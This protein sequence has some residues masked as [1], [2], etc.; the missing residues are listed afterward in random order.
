MRAPP[1]A[2]GIVVLL[3]IIAL[4]VV[5][6]ARAVNTQH[7]RHWN[8]PGISGCPGHA[9]YAASDNAQWILD[10]AYD[11]SY[12]LRSDAPGSLVYVGYHGYWDSPAYVNTLHSD[13]RPLRY[14]FFN[15]AH[16]IPLYRYFLSWEQRGEV[17][18]GVWFRTTYLDDSG[19]YGDNW[20]FLDFDRSE[21]FSAY[22]TPAGYLGFSYKTRET[23]SWWDGGRNYDYVEPSS[24]PHLADGEWHYA[25]FTFKCEGVRR[26]E[27]DRPYRIKYWTCEKSTVRMYRDG[28]LSFTGAVPNGFCLGA[29][30]GRYTGRNHRYG[31]IGDGSEASR[32]NRGRNGAYYTGDIAMVHYSPYK[33]ATDAQVSNMYY[34]TRRYY[35]S[36]AAG[37]YC[38]SFE[39]VTCPAGYYCPG[40]FQKYACGAGNYCPPGSNATNPVPAGFAPRNLD[41]AL[42]T[43]DLIEPCPA[44][45]YCP[46][47]RTMPV[48]GGSSTYCP[49][50]SSAPRSVGAGNYSVGNTPV[51]RTAEVPCNPGQYCAL[52]VPIDC[53]AG[54]YGSTVG[55]ATSACSGN[56]TAGYYCPA[57]SVRRKQEV[58]GIGPDPAATYCPGGHLCASAFLP[59]AIRF[60]RVRLRHDATMWLCAPLASAAPVGYGRPSSTGLVAPAARTAPPRPRSSRMKL[61]PM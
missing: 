61:E 38:D 18:V 45:R 1:R 2:R 31:M 46:G 8:F 34:A 52:G 29:G 47:D 33:T 43:N 4:V 60:R 3:A 56:C 39:A 53:P 15:N 50:G 5:H 24:L 13:G 23:T 30:Y 6:P 57:G 35:Q 36:C 51:N 9:L 26:V 49:A 20:A 37:Y 59:T 40:D 12:Y 41:W 7:C 19:D 48:C 54:A 25:V 21:F 32:F 22:I 44:G 28:V 11:H 10:P 42:T 14:Y 16:H 27:S 58:C 17:T 55:L